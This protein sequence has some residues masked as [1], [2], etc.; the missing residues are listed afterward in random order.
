[1]HGEKERAA[2]EEEERE[3]LLSQM[4]RIFSSFFFLLFVDY[5]PLTMWEIVF[6]FD[7]YSSMRSYHSRMNRVPL[8]LLNR[9]KTKSKHLEE[10]A[11]ERAK[12]QEKNGPT[13]TEWL[14]TYIKKER[15]MKGS[16]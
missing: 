2:D 10:R 8:C 6:T 1:M 5:L 15:K 14:H 4:C 12:G 16:V 3:Y 13:E 9:W 7:L 11:R